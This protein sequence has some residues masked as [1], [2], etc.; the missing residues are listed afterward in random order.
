M[1]GMCSCFIY[2]LCLTFVLI[3]K[4]S[5]MKSKHFRREEFM[6]EEYLYSSFLKK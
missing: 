4:K 1:C 2:W 5:L 3:V 6:S